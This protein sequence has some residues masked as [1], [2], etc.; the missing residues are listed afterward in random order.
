MTTGA[1]LD[2]LVIRAYDKGEWVL[3]TDF[4][5]QAAN[6]VIYVAPKYFV[7]DL[8]STPWI[9]TP[10][11]RGIE[12]RAAGVI[13]DWLYCSQLV[14]REV[15]DLLFQEMVLSLGADPT[16]AK[17]MYWGLRVGA[18][19]AYKACEGGPKVTDLAFELMTP[20][21]TI[22]WKARLQKVVNPSEGPA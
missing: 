3:A 21:E 2:P 13:H 4:R 22:A 6:G 1:F 16:R 9:S 17:M 7:T 18:S 14:S 15:A 20:D 10:F 12:D 19:G 5:Y 8:A 11:L